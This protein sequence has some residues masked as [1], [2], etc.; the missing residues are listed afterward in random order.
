VALNLA[1][2]VGA[3]GGTIGSRIAAVIRGARDALR[4]RRA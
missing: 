3:E 4:L 1:H 2:A